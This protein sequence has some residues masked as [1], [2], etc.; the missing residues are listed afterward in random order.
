MV[1]Q[2][3]DIQQHVYYCP[4]FF[5]FR[6][7][8]GR[9]TKNS[10]TFESSLSS[11]AENYSRGSRHRSSFGE[12]RAMFRQLVSK[13]ATPDDTVDASNV[14]LRPRPVSTHCENSLAVLLQDVV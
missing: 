14:P 7:H 13:E 2:V 11:Y 3:E 5:Q 9:C 10:C 12:L 4:G 6:V 1:L 8:S